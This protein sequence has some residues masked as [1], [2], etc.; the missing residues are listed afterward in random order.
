MLES[1]TRNPKVAS[2]SLRPAEFLSGGS[3]CPALSPPS[4]PQRAALEQGTEQCP[5][6]RALQHKW[7]PTALGVC[8]R[9]VCVCV[10][11][12]CVCVCS[13]LCV[14]IRWVNTEHEFPVWVIIL[15]CMSPHFHFHYWCSS[16]LH[17]SETHR[18]LQSSSFWEVR[19]ALIGQLSSA[20]WLNTSSVR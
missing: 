7:L 5:A 8:S 9:C 1:Q 2:L 3:E 6:P 14:C 19:R 12:Q 13:L 16:M 18:F 11:S 20:L 4:I 15:G 17:L 10:C